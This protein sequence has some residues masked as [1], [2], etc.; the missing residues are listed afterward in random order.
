MTFDPPVRSDQVLRALRELEE[1]DPTR[2]V[3]NDSSGLSIRVMGEIQTEVL[4]QIV[5]DQFGLAIE[6][7]APQILYR[8][9]VLSPSV[10][11]GHYE[12]LRHYA[13]VWLRLSPLAPG[14]GIR[15][16]SKCHVDK[17]ALNW[18]RLIE[19]HVFEREYPGVLTG[20][21]IT[22][23]QIE[24]LAGRAHQKHTEGGDFRES[25]C[26]AIRNAL[27]YA[28]CALLEPVCAFTLRAPAELYRPP[29]RRHD[30]AAGRSANLRCT[31]ATWWKSPARPPS[32][33]F[34]NMPEPAGPDPRPRGPHLPAASLHPRPGRGR[35]CGE[36][37]GGR[38]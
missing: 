23:V 19:T 24:L 22:D 4:A 20:A 38:E 16:V 6:F 2:C 26:R 27:M 21:P 3:E 1:E 33:K 7:G 28:Q 5:R 37:R 31:Q 29:C 9:T 10:G 15:F 32:G 12:P 18:Q 25:T 14:S 34:P 30:P 35:S 11:I 8:E 13:E 36:K 17:L